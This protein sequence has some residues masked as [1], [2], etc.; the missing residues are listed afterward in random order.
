MADRSIAM[1]RLSIIF[2]LLSLVGVM[3]AFELGINMGWST[4]LKF[5]CV[6]LLVM[7]FVTYPFGFII[8][9]LWGFTHKSVGELDE[10]EL[11]ITGK[12]LRIAYAVFS[13]IILIVLYL[14]AVL[15]IRLS[16]VLAAGLLLFAHLLPGT[17]IAFSEKNLQ[18]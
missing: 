8:T 1:T 10:R 9:G 3:V 17:V 15:E 14:F 11:Q 5:I 7:L 6:S 4:I 16:V 18:L 2:T 12:A 13:V